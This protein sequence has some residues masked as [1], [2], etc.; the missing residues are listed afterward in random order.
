[1]FS[2]K[3][4]TLPPTVFCRRGQ[5]FFVSYKNIYIFALWK[6]MAMKRHDIHN[7]LILTPP[8]RACLSGEAL[9]FLNQRVEAAESDGVRAAFRVMPFS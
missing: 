9:S 3:K 2:D 5:I 7:S 6:T 4:H 1:M 8:Q